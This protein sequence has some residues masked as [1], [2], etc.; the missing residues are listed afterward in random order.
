M[1]DNF[2]T[3]ILQ[4]IAGLAVVLALFAILVWM[5]KRLQGKH[6]TQNKHAGIQIIQRFSIDTKHSVIELTHDK[7]S[8]LIG[9]SP[10]GMTKL[11]SAS[12]KS[13]VGDTDSAL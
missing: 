7:K 6:Y 3:L 5:L 2:L 8:Y 1:Q 13:S 9:I 12:H 4:S 10:T 11:S